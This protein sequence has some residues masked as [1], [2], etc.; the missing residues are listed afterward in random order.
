MGA[1]VAVRTNAD[2]VFAEMDRFID[3]ARTVAIPRA[4]NKLIDQAQTAGLRKISDVYGIGPRT[5][6]KYVTTRLATASALEASITAKGKGFPLSMFQP[7]QTRNGVSVRIKD[8]R[9]IVPHAFMATM[10]NGHV[11]VFARGAYGGKGVLVFTGSTFG[12]FKFGRRRLPIN[13]LYTLSP[14]DALSNDDVT[15]AMQDR[16]DQQAAKVLAQE[17]AFASR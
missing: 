2:E 12:R 6:E 16:V 11:G 9:V 8:R 4:M 14:P 15:R 3:Q 10:P 1:R 5:M 17:L 7:R 13:E